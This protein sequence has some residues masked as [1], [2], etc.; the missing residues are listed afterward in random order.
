MKRT[1]QLCLTLGILASFALLAP[2]AMAARKV[3]VIGDS[4]AYGFY[5]N[6]GSQF[7]SHGHGDWEVYGDVLGVP[8]AIPG[9][10]ADNFASNAAGVMDTV[11]SGLVIYPETE[12]VVISLGGNDFWPNYLSQGPAI[13]DAIE[14]DLRVVV[15]QILSVRDVEIVFTG[16]DVLKFD[17]SDVC[18]LFALNFF[19]VVFPWEVTP[20]FMEIGSRQQAIANDYPQVTHLNLFGTC[21]GS[22]GAPNL[23]EWSPSDSV[24][25]DGGDCLHLSEYGE[26]LFTT[27]IYCQYF[28]PRFGES[29]SGPAPWS[30]AS[31]AQAGTLAPSPG[32]KACNGLAFFLAPLAAVL[33]WKGFRKR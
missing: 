11:K 23:A 27:E 6:L 1:I 4:W 33:L 26:T 10:L 7:A 31:D 2:P 18:V 22:P 5:P 24:A 15:D 28:A 12:A 19:G 21:Q 14:S 9:S 20:L 29:C 30:A 8:V 13:F 3:M 16:Y 25:G 17:K 32:S